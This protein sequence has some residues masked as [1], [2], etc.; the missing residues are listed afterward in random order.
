MFHKNDI[1][2]VKE[3]I[4]DSA[5][6]LFKVVTTKGD[7]VSVERVGLNNVIVKMTYHQDDLMH[8]GVFRSNFRDA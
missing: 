4:E 8:V 6:M 2:Q 1:V 7:N 3:S 5:G